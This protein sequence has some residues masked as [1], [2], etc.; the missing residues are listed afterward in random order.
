M[1][2]SLKKIFFIFGFHYAAVTFNLDPKSQIKVKIF[3]YPGAAAL[4]HF[5]WTVPYDPGTAQNT[6]TK[7]ECSPYKMG[8]K[9]SFIEEYATQQPSFNEAIVN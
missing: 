4:Y 1:T 7:K 5:L 2:F 6:F 3:L 8:Q 9:Y